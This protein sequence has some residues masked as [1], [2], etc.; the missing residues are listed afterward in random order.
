[1][2]DKKA[3]ILT[4]YGKGIVSAGLLGLMLAGCGEEQAP[5]PE[6]VVR[7]VKVL[8]LAGSD[9]G[10]KRQY[11]GKVRAAQR[12]DMSFEVPGKLI[13]LPVREGQVL[14]KGEL[15]ARLDDRDLTSNLKSAQAE[16]DNAAANFRR[17]STLVR[18]GNI[19]KTDFDKLQSLK[20]VA[21]ANLT[22]AKKA[23]ADTKLFAP[24]GGRVASRLVENFQDVQAKQPIVSLQDISQLEILIDVPE[25]RA[26]MAARPGAKPPKLNAVFD[27]VS[28]REFPLEVKEFS[29]EADPVTQTFRAVLAMPQPEGMSILPGMTAMVW[30]EPAEPT[31]AS[32][33]AGFNI[34]AAALIADEAGAA[35]VWIVDTQDNTVHRR[36]VETGDLTGSND[37]RVVAGLKAGEILAVSGVSR[38]REGM[39]VRPV[40]KVA[41]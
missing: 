18:D 35:H 41:F 15:I 19:S 32:E 23:V 12:A 14:K 38:L 27:A 22:K 28:G 31:A 40:D 2:S 30:A 29:T 4:G 8:T 17:G 25:N 16:N 13:E 33:A 7:P 3:P 34:P 1:M 10:V 5:A 9:G 20:D 6:L 26:I 36:Q 24:F 11:P 21:A 37:I 39:E